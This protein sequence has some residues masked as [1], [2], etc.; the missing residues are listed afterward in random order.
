MLVIALVSTWNAKSH[1]QCQATAYEGALSSA[2][3]NI[4][5]ANNH[6]DEANS[7]IDQI[8][9]DMETLNN[10]FYPTFSDIR[11]D[12]ESFQGDEPGHAEQVDQ[13]DVDLTACGTS[14]SNE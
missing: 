7:G 1:A 6:I 10:T 14:S 3:A 13:V 11:D 8:N 12:L 5:D 9:N 2:N 4:Q